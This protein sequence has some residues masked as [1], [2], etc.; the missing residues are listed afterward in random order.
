M[1]TNALFTVLILI[2]LTG[3]Y[4]DKEELLYN[5]STC[6]A[7]LSQPAGPNFTNVKNI[8]NAKCSGCHTNGGQSGGANYDGDCKIVD[9]WSK[10]NQRCV[11]VGDMP[12]GG[13]LT[14]A[15]KNQITA[16]VNAGHNYTD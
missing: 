1:K 8:I 11:V 3:C 6:S 7:S 16:W 15:E 10:I 5:A 14:T 9:G 2:F 4:Y 12:P 13:S